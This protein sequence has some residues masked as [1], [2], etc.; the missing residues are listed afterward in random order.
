MFKLEH[1]HDYVGLQAPISIEESIQPVEI[2]I[3][4]TIATTNLVIND[5]AGTKVDETNLV[6][7]MAKYTSRSHSDS[8]VINTN[9]IVI[10]NH[11]WMIK[12]SHISHVSQ[13][14]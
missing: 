5:V 1:I 3:G 12:I 13:V 8:H 10:I 4:S 6:D 11:V 9:I 2:M 14:S 7:S